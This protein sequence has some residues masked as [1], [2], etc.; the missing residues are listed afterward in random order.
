M[1]GIYPASLLGVTPFTSTRGE[2]TE[3]AFP[4]KNGACPIWGGGGLH[5]Q[6]L[7]SE[8]TGRVLRGQAGWQSEGV[9]LFD[10]FV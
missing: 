9:S 2:Q 8:G 10:G 4:A 6:H 5:G 7:A 3:V 1:S